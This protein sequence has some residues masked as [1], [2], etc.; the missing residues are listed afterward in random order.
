MASSGCWL[1]G[2]LL[3]CWQAGW[4]A[5]WLA[6]RLVY[7]G[8][9]IRIRPACLLIFIRDT[10]YGLDPHASL[11]NTDTGYGYGIDSHASLSQYGNLLANANGHSLSDNDSYYMVLMVVFVVLIAYIV[12]FLCHMVA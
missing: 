2:W 10:G 11:Y 9:G 12:F 4:L 1:A 8:Y 3:V 6:G 5:G 7:T